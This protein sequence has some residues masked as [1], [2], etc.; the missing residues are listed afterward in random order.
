MSTITTS[1]NQ[2]CLLGKM[3]VADWAKQSKQQCDAAIKKNS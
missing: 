1:L 2:Q 3:S